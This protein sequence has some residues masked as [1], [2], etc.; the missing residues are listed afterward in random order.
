MTTCN[1]ISYFTKRV[2]KQLFIKL[3]IVKDR[4]FFRRKCVTSNFIKIASRISFICKDHFPSD[5]HTPKT[6]TK[7]HTKH[8]HARARKSILRELFIRTDQFPMPFVRE[9]R[10]YGKKEKKNMIPSYLAALGCRWILD[11]IVDDVGGRQ[12]R[13]RRGAE[14]RKAEWATGVA[15]AQGDQQLLLSHHGTLI[16]TS[17]LS[18]AS[19]ASRFFLYSLSRA[20]SLTLVAHSGTRA[21]FPK[22]KTER[23]HD[24]L[25]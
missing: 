14:Q 18:F 3:F 6:H 24:L 10:P 13:R 2:R 1:P 17:S 9:N 22:R 19:R 7:K 11:D 20:R 21:I 23:E 16:L 4:F 15:A 8:T 12:I 5:G 25:D